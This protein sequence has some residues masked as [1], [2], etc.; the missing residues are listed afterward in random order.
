MCDINFR[1]FA[2]YE[3]GKNMKYSELEKQLKAAGCYEITRKGGH[4]IWFSPKTGKRFQ[5]SHHGSEEV[6]PGTLRSILRNA[7]IK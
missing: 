2:S 6:K 4:P 1:I 7:G 3:K 5:T